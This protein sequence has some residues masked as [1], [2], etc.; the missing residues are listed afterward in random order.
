MTKRVLA[1]ALAAVTLAACGS[2][3][4]HHD[5]GASPTPGASTSGSATPAPG[6]T[7]A[8]AGSQTTSGPSRTGEPA[9]SGSA[10]SGT[11]P[12]TQPNARTTVQVT[13]SK[14]CVRP[15]DAMTLTATASR[16]NMTLIF[17]TSYPDGK[18]GQVHGGIEKNGKT[19]SSGHYT[20]TW[21]VDRTT[22]PGDAAVLLSVI[23][24]QGNAGSRTPF[25]IALA[26]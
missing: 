12:T 17:D 3:K 25:R 26:C 9:T 18:D 8:P 22:P 16:P 7:S 5:A 11:S 19:D 6:T 1:A 24:G 20:S 10:G 15:G 23:D 13:L 2:S 21:T 14:T 4:P